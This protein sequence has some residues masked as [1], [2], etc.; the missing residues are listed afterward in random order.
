MALTDKQQAF[1]DAYIQCRYNATQAALRAGY[2]KKTARQ[3]GSR[4]LSNV[5]I[6]AAIDARLSEETLS[7]NEALRLLADHATGSMDDFINE[8][9][10]VDLETARARGK[11][12]L[13]NQYKHIATDGQERV[14]VKLYDA[15]SALK[16]I[17]KLHRLD[18]GQSTDN[19]NVTVRVEY[20][21]RNPK[22]DQSP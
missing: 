22:T 11:T 6:R 1:I 2:A 20:V 4:L 14:E 13:I 8:A 9:G 21:N 12:H 18:A 19:Q 7:A 17:I 3:Q 16:E 15:Q 5:D 10:Y